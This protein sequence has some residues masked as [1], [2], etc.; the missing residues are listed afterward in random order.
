MPDVSEE[1]LYVACPE[2][3]R[4]PVPSVVAPSLNVTV[5][6]GVPVPE[7]GATVA[8]NITDCPTVDGFAEEIRVVMV[9]P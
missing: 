4:V 7:L 9:G 1:V 8:V 6:V 5:P 2:P 3:F